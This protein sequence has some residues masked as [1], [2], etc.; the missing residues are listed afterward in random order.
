ME[1]QEKDKSTLNTKWSANDIQ[2]PSAARVTTAVTVISD[3]DRSRE[4]RRLEI[5]RILFWNA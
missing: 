3:N 1:T 5:D 2:V 4:I